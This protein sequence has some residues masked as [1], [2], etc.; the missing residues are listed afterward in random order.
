QHHTVKQA[1]TSGLA[2]PSR[3]LKLQLRPLN[4]FSSAA[5]ACYKAQPLPV[6][7]T[8]FLFIFTGSALHLFVTGFLM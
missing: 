6:N 4:I 7:I 2:N 8:S 3:P 1:P 5:P